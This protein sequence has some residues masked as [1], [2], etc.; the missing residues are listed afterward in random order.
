[1]SLAARLAAVRARLAAACDAAGGWLSAA[2][3]WARFHTT[4]DEVAA[5]R[6]VL[7]TWYPPSYRRKMVKVLPKRA[8]SGLVEV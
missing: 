2:D 5:V 8:S 6:P 1:M 3:E 4:G 7:N